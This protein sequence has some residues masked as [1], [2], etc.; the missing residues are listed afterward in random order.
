MSETTPRMSATDAVPATMRH[1]AVPRPGGPDAIRI[2]DGPVPRPRPGEAL[3]RVRAAGINRPDLLQRAGNYDPPPDASPLLGLEV[4]G[5]VA[6]LGDGVTTL[7]LG[8]D[9]TALVNGGGYAEF[10]TAPAGQCLPFPAG[11]DAVQAAALPENF[12]TV[13]SNVFTPEAE[14]GGALKPGETI[15]VHGGTSG[16]GLAAL[17]LAAALGAR[18]IA[19]AGTAEKCR[20]AERYGAS[21]A[22]DRREDWPARV[23]ELTGGRGCDV[24]LDVAGGPAL[25]QNL[26]C[27][28]MDGRLVLIGFMAGAVAER[29]SLVPIAQRRLRITGS[30]LRPRTP[31]AKARIAAA[32][33]AHVWPLLEAGTVRPVIDGVFPLDEAAAAHARLES[34]AALG[35]IVLRMS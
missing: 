18:A 16:I 9:V 14:G 31:A 22:I 13:W 1:A 24:V 4:A 3:I 17:Q 23:A 30:T 29:V 10:C 26:A 11:L 8:E 15:L 33:R 20:A 7:A 19:T 21:A 12:F 25:A 27:L 35:K 28:G 5:S 6:A 32:L 34:G 2:V